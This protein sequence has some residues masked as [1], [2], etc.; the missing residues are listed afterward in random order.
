MRITIR[1]DDITP[2][3]NWD[4]FLRFKAILDK[5]DIKPLIGVVPDCQDEKL[6]IDE[7]R[8]DFW[9][10]V[11]G[12][13]QEGW[14][15]AMHGYSHV[16][17]TNNPGIFPIG[18]KSEF[19]GLPYH[20]QDEMIRRGRKIMEDNGVKTDIFMAPSHS[21]DRN[22]LKALKANGFYGL[23][24]G[25]GITPFRVDGLVFFPIS[26]SR[27]RSLKD[28]RDGLVTFVYHANTMNDKDFDDLERLMETAEVVQYPEFKRIDVEDRTLFGEIR[29]YSVAKAKYMAVR[30]RGRL[31][32]N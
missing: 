26:V 10:Y 19:A 16:Y 9:E 2:G 30:L 29:Q 18:S 5:Y 25:F 20:Q 15:V 6:K 14:Y 3:M 28:S 24:D 12:L 1:M 27:G 21:F 7:D 4:K 8:P 13:Q 11:R 32:K 31:K 23:T 22:T 17:T